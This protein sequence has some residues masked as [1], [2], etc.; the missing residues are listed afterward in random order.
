MIQYLDDL[1]ICPDDQRKCETD[2]VA[3]LQ[4]LAQKGHKVSKEKLQFAQTMVMYLGHVLE[5][6]QRSLGDERVETIL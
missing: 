1:L 3:L 5:Q 4:A 6:G 2:T